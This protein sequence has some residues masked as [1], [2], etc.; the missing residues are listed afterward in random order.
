ML[1]DVKHTQSGGES[2]V[3]FYIIAAASFQQILI[4]NRDKEQNLCVVLFD[5]AFNNMDSQR[6][7][8]MMKFYKELNIQIFLSLTGEKLHSIAKYVDSTIVIV[9]DGL[10]AEVMPFEGDFSD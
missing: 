5:E 9:R 4:R 10:V 1:S 2:Q 8:S 3:P 6:V 7:S